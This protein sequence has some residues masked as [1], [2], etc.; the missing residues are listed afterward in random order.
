MPMPNYMRRY[1]Y[2]LLGFMSGYMGALVVG[3]ISVRHGASMPLR[4]SFALVTAMMICGV[5][6]A[7]FRLLAECDDEYQRLLLVK[8]VLFA[9]AG[10]LAI[11]TFW[12]FLA[13]F[14]VIREGP[15]WVGALWLAMF[16][17]AAPVARWRA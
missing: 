8:Q 15:E 5:F 13:V 6:W 3:L 16:G 11:V 17:L 7:I 10:T 4:V 2:R 12:Q 1:T 9:T 14:D